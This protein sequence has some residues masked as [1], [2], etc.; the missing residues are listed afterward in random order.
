M[1]GKVVAWSPNLG[2]SIPAGGMA[3]VCGSDGPSGSGQCAVETMNFSVQAEA[4]NRH[5]ISE[6]IESNNLSARPMH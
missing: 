3:L 5:V 1:N 2:R 4:D 6:T